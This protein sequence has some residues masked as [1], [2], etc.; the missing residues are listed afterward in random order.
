CLAYGGSPDVFRD[1]A[2]GFLPAAR[3]RNC[4]GEYQKVSRAFTKT[5]LPYIDQD[6]MKKVQGRQWLRPTDLR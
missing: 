2:N 4:A 3:A 1:L 6:M 5:V